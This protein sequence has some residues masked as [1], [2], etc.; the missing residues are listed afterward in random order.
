MDQPRRSEESET[1]GTATI[2]KSV[3]KKQGREGRLPSTERG[4]FVELAAE[5]HDPSRAMDRPASRGCARGKPISL[6]R[7]LR[8]LDLCLIS[9]SSHVKGLGIIY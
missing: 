8:R 3:N 9:Q 1:V 2:G 4:G 6:F 5:A 7:F